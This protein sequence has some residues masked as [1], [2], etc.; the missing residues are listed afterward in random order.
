[1][2]SISLSGRIPLDEVAVIL[3]VCVDQ[4][5]VLTLS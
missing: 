2:S 1:M 5:N 3:G 4:D